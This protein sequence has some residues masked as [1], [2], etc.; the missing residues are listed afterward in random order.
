MERV[1][2]KKK[3]GNKSKGFIFKKKLAKII[4]KNAEAD[5]IENIRDMVLRG[6]FAK[7]SSI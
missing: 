2:N 3:S 5:I 4:G 7:E 6:A 1:G